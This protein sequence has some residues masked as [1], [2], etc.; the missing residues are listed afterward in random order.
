VTTE[1]RLLSTNTQ[2]RLVDLASKN[3]STGDLP[4]ST[5]PHKPKPKNPYACTK[6]EKQRQNNLNR[7]KHREGPKAPQPKGWEKNSANHWRPVR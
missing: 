5:I 7:I 1:E 3:I 2:P 4:T 6:T